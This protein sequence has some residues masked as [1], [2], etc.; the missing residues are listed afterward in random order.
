ML[1]IV[2]MVNYLKTCLQPY[3]VRSYCS[4]TID[5][6]ELVDVMASGRTTLSKPDITGCLQLF[7][8]ELIKL[9]A[10][11]KHVK[12]PIGSFYLAA[13]GRLEAKN[14]AFTPGVGALDHALTLHFRTDKDAEGKIKSQARWERVETFDTTAAAIDG[15][16]VVARSPGENA[17]SGDTLRITGRRLKFDPAD[18]ECGVFVESVGGSWRAAVY[19]D[20]APSKVIATLPA[21]VPAGT[22]DFMVITKPNGKDLKTGYFDKPF[23]IA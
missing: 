22:Y 11:G 4:D 5:V 19:A 1:Q 3:L 13:S 23:V 14:Q 16:S 15:Y 18:A 12:T 8:E 6:D 9:V 7:T 2:S 20:I 17:R 21:D 10:D